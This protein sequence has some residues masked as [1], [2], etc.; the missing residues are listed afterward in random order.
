M[1]WSQLAETLCVPQPIS[2]PRPRIMIGGGGERK[3]LRLV[4]RY[5]DECNLFFQLGLD[6]IRRKLDVLRVH[7]EAVGR[8]C[9]TVGR[10][11]AGAGESLS[12]AGLDA[13]TTQM[14]QYA[15]IGVDT[16]I[17]VPR[18]AYARPSGCGSTSAPP[19]SAHRPQLAR[20]LRPL[21]RGHGSVR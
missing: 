12:G 15:K 17:L 13:F 8:D 9:G 3:T 1:R 10:T 14:S 21:S 11:T 4:A 20:P 2:S 7:C 5:A 18:R 16:V 6:E 19:P